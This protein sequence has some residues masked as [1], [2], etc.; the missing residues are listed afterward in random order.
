LKDA[1]AQTLLTQDLLRRVDRA[2]A[3]SGVRI[4]S[5]N[6]HS[7]KA[8][9][10]AERSRTELQLSAAGPYRALKNLV[11]RILQTDSR[12]ALDRVSLAHGSEST[13]ELDLQVGF[14]L[15]D[16]QRQ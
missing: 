3:A 15:V 16:W 2:A 8:T 7:A 6:L 9:S 1:S 11:E 12:L 4:G 10:D 14:H 5:V 13:D